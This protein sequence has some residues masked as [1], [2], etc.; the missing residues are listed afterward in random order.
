MK[1]LRG[2]AFVPVYGQIST[3]EMTI[4]INDGVAETITIKVSQ[5]GNFNWTE[6]KNIDYQLD[7]G[8]LDSV[9]E[10]DDVPV[11]LSFAFKWDFIASATTTE[12]S[13]EDALKKIG[14]ASDWVTTDADNCPYAVD[15][16][17]EY[18]PSC[19]GKGE[20]YTFADFRYENLE[21]DMNGASISCTGKC[22]IVRPTTVVA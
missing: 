19:G 16:E 22:N 3:R 17:V 9:T 12:I 7:R 14:G 1:L 5:G 21:H 18:T 4:K 10:G 8:H 15:I 11:E 20:T 6:A 13:P 2:K